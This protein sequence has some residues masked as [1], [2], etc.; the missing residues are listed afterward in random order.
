MINYNLN[1]ELAFS[2]KLMI[3]KFL[4]EIQRRILREIFATD[5]LI[6]HHSYY[7]SPYKYL[8]FNLQL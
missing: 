7:N 6:T 2:Y 8:Y 4:F 1:V 5:I 3:M